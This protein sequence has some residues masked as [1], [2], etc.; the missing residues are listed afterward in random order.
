MTQPFN[1]QQ[2]M[3]G[4][5]ALQTLQPG[6]EPTQQPLPSNKHVSDNLKW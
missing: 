1:M 2:L 5:A 4:H 3:S 6:L